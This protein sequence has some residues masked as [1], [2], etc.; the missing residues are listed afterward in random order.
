MSTVT[1]GTPRSYTDRGQPAVSASVEVDGKRFDIFFRCARGPLFAGAEPFLVAALLPAMK[2]G[3]NIVVQSSVAA[4]LLRHIDHVQSL[5]CAWWPGYQRVAV[6]A[7]P[8]Q[9]TSLNP[10]R[11]V[12]CFFSG[13]V[14]SFYSVLTR[15][16]EINDLVFVHGLDM[17]LKNTPLRAKIAPAI[18]RAAG[19]LGKP[20]IEIETNV[21]DILDPYTNWSGESDGAAM[22]A[23]GHVL[24]LQH[25]LI[26]LSSGR[27]YSKRISTG[28]AHPLLLQLWGTPEIELSKAG[29]ETSRYQKLAYLVNN[30]TAMRWLRVCWEHTNDDYNCC[31]CA[32]CLSTMLNLQLL[33]AL[34]RC[35]TFNRPLDLEL[36][37]KIPFGPGD[38]RHYEELLA[39]AEAQGNETIA[40]SLRACLG[41]TAET[42]DDTRYRDDLLRSQRRSHNLERKLTTLRASRS[43]RMTRPLRDA[44]RW[45]RTIRETLA[46]KRS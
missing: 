26:Y 15:D 33:G 6:R 28:G 4:H 31:Q 17:T 16:D 14:D 12:G 10:A 40:E 42:K 32:K 30:E 45:L 24:S 21:R 18:R 1:I 46:W 37:R 36:L 3:A 34:D 19:E 39:V 7:T 27:P 25:Q 11:G 13:G 41:A 9:I 5:A 38:R 23:L 43:W 22:A 20:L 29:R 44:G 2:L 8:R 35:R